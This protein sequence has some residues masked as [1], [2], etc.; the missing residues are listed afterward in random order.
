MSANPRFAPDFLL[1]LALTLIGGAL[2]LWLLT[3]G[4]LPRLGVFTPIFQFLLFSFD[5]FAA[6]AS[7]ILVLFAVAIAPFCGGVN[8][9][10]EA[11]ARHP[12]K[13]AAS[14]WVVMALGARY[15]YHAHPLS[16][17]EYA[18][19]FQSRAFAAGALAGKFPPTWL[20]HLIPA[21]FQNYF[22][23]MSSSTGEVASAYWPGFAL[24]MTPF[25]AIGMEWLC[26]P[27]LAALSLV[28]IARTCDLVFPEDKAIAGWAMLFALAS[29]VFVALG[30]SYYAMTALLL[31][32]LVFVWGFLAPTPGRLFVSG[33]AGSAAL[34]MHNPAPH[35][36]FAAPW[37]L[38]FLY[39]RPDWRQLLALAAGYAPLVLILGIGWSLFK[40]HLANGAGAAAPV[41]SA[42]LSDSVAFQVSAAFTAPTT[43]ILWRRLAGTIKLWV[44]AVPGLLVLAGLG[45]ALRR[46]RVAVRLLGASA[47][48]T[49]AGYFFVPFDQGHG[50]GY[51]YFHSAWS[52]LPILAGAAV[53]SCAR[54]AIPSPTWT[55]QRMAG[56]LVVA[57][58]IVLV[59][60]QLRNIDEFI[61]SFLAQVPKA[62]AGE[63]SVVF[64]YPGQGFYLMDLV[65]NDPFLRDRNMRMV[66]RGPEADAKFLQ[67]SGLRATPLPPT[68]LGQAWILREKP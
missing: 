50:W 49:F 32:N 38:W 27:T 5:R 36:L 68:P 37:L 2:C 48:L 29:P 3:P 33:L 20:D 43:D 31:A 47:I 51:R 26:N 65:Q 56:G 12:W 58:M 44:W 59:P 66:G 18:V 14:C 16:M 39:R 60:L 22:L 54:T 1:L 64:L 57:S 7:L 11:L 25:S 28:A 17:D 55:L 15:I 46:D 21:Q 52:V 4:I 61:G 24:L 13:V 53:A 40:V 8:R 35:L 34:V 67:Q 6:Q 45:Y 23:V 63:A 62:P 30:I 10:A 41:G 19:W 42:G 9:V